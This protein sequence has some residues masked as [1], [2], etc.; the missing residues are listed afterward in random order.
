[1]KLTALSPL[2]F[3]P[4]VRARGLAQSLASLD[5]R[6]VY[7]VDVGF[8]NSDAFMIQLQDWLT[9][10]EPGISTELVRWRDMHKPDPDLCLRIKHDG[11]AAILGVGL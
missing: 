5:G 10:H 6:K 4:R 8:E 11:D 7:L 2:G 9:R 1:M 3:P